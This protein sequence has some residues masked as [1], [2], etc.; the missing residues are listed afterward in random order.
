MLDVKPAEPAPK[1]RLSRLEE[2][3]RVRAAA[4]GGDSGSAESQAADT[5]R[6]VLI[7]RELLVY[8][9]EHGQLDV[10]AF[11][12][13]GFWNR[14]GI[15]SVSRRRARSRLWRKCL[16]WCLSLGCT[17]ISRPSAFKPSD[18]FQRSPTLLVT[19]AVRRM[20]DS[21]YFFKCFVAV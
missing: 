16:I 4:G 6:R 20:L 7:G 18:F 2:R 13:L 8:L 21:A 11:N 15:D 17:M 1:T 9:A 10:D 14:R 12:L 19:C 3:A 5:G